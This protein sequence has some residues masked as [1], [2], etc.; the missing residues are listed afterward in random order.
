MY[1]VDVN[2]LVHAFGKASP[3]HEACLRWMD[4]ALAERRVVSLP[5]ETL[6]GFLR[7][8]TNRRI[9]SVPSSPERATQ[10]TDWLVAHPRTLIPADVDGIYAT[11]RDLIR[12]HDLRGNDVPDAVLAAT[13]MNLGAT[14]VTSD[15]GFRRFS[16]LSLL[17]PTAV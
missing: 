17:D 1:C 16:A 7:I 11:S 12:E 2:I 8:V 10:F 4:A 9:F 5:Q 14:L 6:S 15:R 3:S 13:A